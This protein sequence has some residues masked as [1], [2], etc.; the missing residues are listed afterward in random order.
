[1]P[2]ISIPQHAQDAPITINTSHVCLQ[3][4][5]LGDTCCVALP[6][7]AHL[8]FPLS[9]KEWERIAPYDSLASVAPYDSLASVAP[10]SGSASVSPEV[11]LVKG[12][13]QGQVAEYNTAEFVEAVCGLF[14]AKDKAKIEQ[15]FPMRGKH[16]RLRTRA[17]GSCVFLGEAGCKLP[18]SVRPWYCLLFPLWF[19]E[20]EILLF[21]M[22]SC[23]VARQ[24]LSPAHGLRMVGMTQKEALELFQN[25][26]ADWGI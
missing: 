11:T 14:S 21:A 3:C 5:S 23:L 13:V 4:A 8:A 25:L 24:A 22:E 7:Q 15:I 1:M 12:S 9:P 6:E 20:G 2:K 17:D 16:F 19:S 26:R 10:A 18:R